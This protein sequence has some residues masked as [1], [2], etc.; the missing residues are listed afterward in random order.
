M[1]DPITIIVW[2][3][4]I[5][6]ALWLVFELLKRL[7]IDGTLKRIIE[8][9]IIAIVLIAVLLYVFRPLLGGA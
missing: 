4:V 2:I 1:G 9:A 8:I 3:I 7:P 6:L 5:A